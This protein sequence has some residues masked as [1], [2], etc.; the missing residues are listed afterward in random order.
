MFFGSMAAVALFSEPLD[1]ARI[2]YLYHDTAIR[3]GVHGH[4]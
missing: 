2:R 1:A 4:Q 3:V